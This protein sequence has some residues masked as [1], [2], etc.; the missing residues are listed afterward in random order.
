MSLLAPGFS[1]TFGLDGTA[2][3]DQPQPPFLAGPP[4]GA[5]PFAVAQFGTFS[6]A[7]VAARRVGALTA[8]VV[9]A[10]GTPDPARTVVAPTPGTPDPA[11]T[12][13]TTT[14]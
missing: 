11:R 7:M 5:S 4:G 6:I 2:S 8:T 12:T 9:P 1:I 13:I 14:R 3:G 10:A